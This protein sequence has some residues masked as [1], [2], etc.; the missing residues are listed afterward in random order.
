MFS[1]SLQLLGHFALTTR[2]GPVELPCLGMRAV[3]FV[4]C[5]GPV[6][7]ASLIDTLWPEARPERAASNLRSL[8]WRLRRTPCPVESRGDLLQVAD[9]Q[10]DLHEEKE[11]ARQVIRGADRAWREAH[12]R[13]SFHR[14]VLPA[15]DD[16]WLTAE[17]EQ[18]R[19]LRLTALDRVIDELLADSRAGEAVEVALSTAAMDPLRESTQRALIR[20]HLAMGNVADAMRQFERFREQLE[21]ELGCSPSPALYRLMRSP[22]AETPSRVALASP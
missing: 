7:R 8:L 17:R 9:A 16:A 20:A 6:T 19:Q 2:C 15:W 12:D 4:A 21:D 14:D 3:A 18:F 11:L 22:V 5:N 1:G 13:R 10:V